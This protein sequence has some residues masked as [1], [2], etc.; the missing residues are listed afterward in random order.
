MSLHE[1]KIHKF[2]PPFKHIARAKYTR[3]GHRDSLLQSNPN[4][5]VHYKK[6]IISGLA[7]YLQ[8]MFL[9]DMQRV[10]KLL[11]LITLTLVPSEFGTFEFS[12]ALNKTQSGKSQT[13]T[14]QT[15]NYCLSR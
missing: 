3:T 4:V 6:Q 2:Q 11:V 14:E 15:G 12:K 13:N 8:G 7:A 10:M 5:K 1:Q 9:D